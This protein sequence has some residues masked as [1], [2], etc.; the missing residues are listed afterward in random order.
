MA[1]DRL[2]VFTGNSIRELAEDV[3]S[4][5]NIHL[6]RAKVGR[7]SDGEV[8]VEILENVRGKDV[9]V[10][11]SICA[12][13]NDNLMELLVMV[14]ALKRASAG[15]VTAAIPYM[16]YAR[17][18]RRPSS[19]RVPITAKVVANM[20]TSAGVDRVLTMDLHSEQI[21]RLFVFPG[22]N[23]LSGPILLGVGW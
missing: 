9:F 15:R 17:Q 3:V 12:P 8:M 22:V 16:G 23:I 20:M 19:A 4:H 21:H 18:D 6:G 2:M 7:F 10:L 5:L 11:Q 13:T 14:D 1:L